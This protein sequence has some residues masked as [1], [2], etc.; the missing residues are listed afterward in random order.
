MTAQ[1][2]KVLII[3]GGIG[4]L[5]AGIAMR[6]AG[7]DATVFE[8]ST[9]AQSAGAG[10][11][12]VLW[13]NGMRVLQYLGVVDEIHARA[14]RPLS[15]FETRTANG[16]MVWSWCVSDLTRKIG[17]PYPVGIKRAELHQVLVDAMPEGVL[18]LGCDC[19]GFEQ[20]DTGVTAFFKGGRQ[21]RGDILI[22][23]Q[24]IRS[25]IRDQILGPSELRYSG[26][27]LWH[28]IVDS[29]HPIV[30]D[31]IFR[32]LGAPAVRF[33]MFP[34]NDT[35]A[36]WSCIAKAP[37]GA[38]DPDGRAK[39]ELLRLTAGFMPP[40]HDLINA[41]DSIHRQDVLGRKATKV[42]GNGRVTMMGDAV[43]PT[44]PMLGQGASQAM[45][46][47]VAVTQSL[48]RNAN[49]VM[50]LREYE[51]RRMKRAIGV[52]TT[53]WRIGQMSMLENPMYTLSI[54]AQKRLGPLIVKG[55]QRTISHDAT[56]A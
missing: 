51:M 40:T 37:Q 52:M 21:E 32:E 17:S 41:S 15:W 4:G 5:A 12:F 33:K 31:G 24:G 10:T 27:T 28:T 22:A 55:Y 7:I 19:T 13:N 47:A 14:S 46:D 20:D 43:H 50:A 26:F 45:E 29:D 44:T 16:D 35:Q 9:S 25:G 48:G 38:Q 1:G 34:V 36:Y 3:G 49:P 39:E 42:W 23:A 11:A 53:S 56:V 6:R 8:R 30:W 2:I 54:R 18:Q